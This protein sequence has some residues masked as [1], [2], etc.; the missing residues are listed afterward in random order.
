M[1]GVCL[2]CVHDVKAAAYLQPFVLPN[3]AVAIR[4]FGD[5]VN[6]EGHGFHAHPS[7]YT[8]FYV[9][10]FDSGSGCIT[11]DEPVSLG[12]GVAFVSGVPGGVQQE[13][14]LPPIKGDGGYVDFVKERSN[15]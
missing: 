12:N 8:L 14:V 7:D 10:S 2:Y 3:D 15:A 4:T 13:L 11:S 5:M 1:L 9:G 6:Q